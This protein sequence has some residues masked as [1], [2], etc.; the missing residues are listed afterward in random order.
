MY[1]SF[2]DEDFIFSSDVNIMVYY[3]KKYN[4]DYSLEIQSVWCILTFGYNIEDN[5]MF[6]EIKR[7][8]PGNYIIIENDEIHIIKKTFI[9]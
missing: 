1:Y 4:F 7:I 5:T 9:D 3:F 6:E 2:I 8:I